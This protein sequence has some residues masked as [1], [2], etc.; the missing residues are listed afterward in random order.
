MDLRHAPAEVHIDA[1]LVRA[2]LRDQCPRLAS[3]PLNWIDEG[4]D[5]VTYRV[6]LDHAV[7]IPRRQAAVDLLLAEQRWLPVI[8][9]RLPIAVPRPV[10]LGVPSDR[11]PWP[12][13]VV[14][15]IR[16]KTVDVSPLTADQAES[17]ANILLALH[18]PAPDEAPFNPFRGVPLESRQ[19]VVEERLGRLSLNE[20]VPIWQAAIEAPPAEKKLWIHGDLHPRNVLVRKGALAGIIDWGDMTGGDVATDIACAWMLFDSARGRSAFFAAYDPSKAARARAAG[21]AVN[22]VSALLR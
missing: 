10:G 20:L 11:F 22:F 21:W 8:G 9:P 16:G 1:E 14:E 13:S 17:F 2:L 15:W 6:G 4:W 7:R 5:N 19:G 18:R 3:E 12:W